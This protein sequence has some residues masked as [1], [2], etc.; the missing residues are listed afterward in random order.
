MTRTRLLMGAGLAAALFAGVAIWLSRSPAPGASSAVAPQLSFRPGA[1]QAYRLRVAS[2]LRFSGGGAGARTIHQELTGT[3]HLRVLDAGADGA[4]VALQLGGASLSLGGQSSQE[5]DRQLGRLF[6]ATFAADGTVRRLEFPGGIGEDARMAL[7][8]AVRTFQVV[9]PPGAGASW[10]VEEEHASGRYRAAYRATTDGR[11]LKAKVG[12][13][14]GAGATGI[15]VG[16]RRANATARIDR[17]AS[18][19]ERM[20]DEEE[21][22]V[23]LGNGL[24]TAASLDAELARVTLELA[25]ASPLEIDQA[26]GSYRELSAALAREPP[27]PGRSSASP[28]QASRSLESMLGELEASGGRSVALR[29]DLRDLLIREPAAAARVVSLLRAGV[30]DRTAAVLL[31]ALGMASTDEAQAALR[32]VME[33]PGFGGLNR[34][35]AALALGS[36]PEIGWDSLQAL[37]RLADRAEAHSDGLAD[38]AVLALGIAADTLRQARSR[39][40]DEVRA[41]LVRRAEAARDGGEEATALL[42][43]G[44][45]GDPALAGAAAE[46]LGDDSPLA[47]SAAAHALARLG[48]GTDPDALARRLSVEG[49]E[50]V[51][52]T[53]AASLNA[54]PPPSAATL[55][56]VNEAIRRENDPQARYDMARLLGENL[57]TYPEARATLAALARADPSSR[58]RT[59]AAHAAWGRGR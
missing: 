21:L 22:T 8:E 37:R 15:R 19:L 52:S 5:L 23:D 48:G 10:S 35:R 11:I 41:D 1:R 43:L 29:Y 28:S 2:A 17:D 55:A 39:Q 46:H 27:G 47:R 30:A 33:D 20:V 32:Q 12:Y 16:V 45:T 14:D 7:A 4:R 58:V 44:N 34:T 54:L 53:I 25:G 42:A 51:R 24:A 56:L 26:A 38:T 9:I 3:L 18:W 57:A 40:Y 49:H 6:L 59:Y 31:N 36:S 50:S 13:L